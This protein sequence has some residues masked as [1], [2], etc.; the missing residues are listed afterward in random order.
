MDAGNMLKPALARGELH[1]VGATTLDEY[2]KY[3]EK[4][5]A[6]ERRFQKVLVGEPSVEDTIAI[7]RGLQG[8]LRGAP[9]RGHHRPG[10]RGRGRTQP[11]LHHR[12]LFARQGD[13]PDR[14]GGGQDQDR[15]RL[16]AR[17]HGQA[18]SP[19]DPAQ[20]RARGR[21]E[22][23]GRGLAKAPGADQRGN[24]QAGEG[25]RRPGRNLA[26]RESQRPGQRAGAQ[27]HRAN[28]SSRSRKLTRKGDFNKVAE[29]QY[30]KLPSWKSSSKKRRP[31]E[32]GARPAGPSCC[33]RKS[34]PKR[35][36]RWSAAPPA[37]PSAR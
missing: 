1:C 4:D 9:R 33:A 17:G 25:I 2:R 6:L 8:A 18:G 11:P 28:S 21:E 32:E 16:Q 5:A 27:G 3:I 24:G 37:S 22:G 15:D 23:K 20:D 36:P 10:H 31:S 12:P 34:A 13:R 7:L 29:L 19:H 26:C 35:L 30:G 14:R